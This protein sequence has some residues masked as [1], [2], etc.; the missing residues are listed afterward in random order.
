M[1]SEVALEHQAA[2]QAYLDKSK[3]TVRPAATTAAPTTQESDDFQFSFDS[4]DDAEFEQVDEFE[5]MEEG[6]EGEFDFSQIQADFT[7]AEFVEEAEEAAEEA[8]LE[9]PPNKGGKGGKGHHG[10]HPG[11]GKGG[12]GKAHGKDHD[13]DGKDHDKDG[14]KKDGKNQ[15]GKP[16]LFTLT[17]R[18]KDGIDK[19]KQAKKTAHGHA[20]MKEKQQHK[21]T[22]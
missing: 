11:K 8:K 13:K 9:S 14:H 15:G 4:F 12:K 7:G 1:G 19:A 3:N 10:K 6:F 5:G 20:Q 16:A 2:A 17:Y 18:N 22:E 21:M